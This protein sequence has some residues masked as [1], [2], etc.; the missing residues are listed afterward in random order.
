MQ[1]KL[2]FRKQ[3]D[4]KWIVTNNKKVYVEILDIKENYANIARKIEQSSS[5]LNIA[6]I[7]ENRHENKNQL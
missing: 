2:L 7:F 4:M 5:E 6:L 3:D 1:A